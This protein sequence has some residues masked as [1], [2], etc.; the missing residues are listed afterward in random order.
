MNNNSKYRGIYR[1]GST[2]TVH[3]HFTDRDGNAQQHKRGGFT[4]LQEARRYHADYLSQIH[5]GRRSGTTKLRLGD[6]LQREWLPHRESELKTTTFNS[7]KNVIQAHIIPRLG[8][9]RL[10]DLNARRKEGETVG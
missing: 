4:T 8:E 1:R 6:Y 7:Y 5:S 2:W 3:I 10:E 9:I